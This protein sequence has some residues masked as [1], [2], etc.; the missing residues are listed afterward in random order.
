M[1]CIKDETTFKEAKGEEEEKKKEKTEAT[2]Q[3]QK[4]EALNGKTKWLTNPMTCGGEVKEKLKDC[5]QRF[6]ILMS[7]E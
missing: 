7:E 3:E 4:K 5:Q 2:K 1:Y 6:K